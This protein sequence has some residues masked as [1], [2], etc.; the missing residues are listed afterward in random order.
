MITVYY[1]VKVV[2]VDPSLVWLPL[3]NLVNIYKH[4]TFY[5]I[6]YTLYFIHTHFTLHID[7]Q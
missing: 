2:F 4:F 1:C 7:V 5:T 6:L 3:N